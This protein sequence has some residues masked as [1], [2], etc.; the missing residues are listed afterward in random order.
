MSTFAP[1]QLPLAQKHDLCLGLLEEFGI[2]VSH[3]NEDKHELLHACRLPWHNEKT[4]SASLN[5]DKLAFRCFGCDSKGGLLWFIATMRGNSSGREVT[6]WLATATG[7]GGHEVD[8]Q[9]LLDY[10]EA[11]YN[12]QART[13]QVIP[14]FSPRVLEPWALVHP[15][16]TEV[17][18]IPEANLDTLQI[19]YDPV[20]DK[21]IIPHFWRDNLV[22]WQARK[23]P[24]NSGPKYKNTVDFPRESTV[25]NHRPRHEGTVVLVESPMSVLRH[26]HH[27]HMVSTFGSVVTDTQIR[28]LADYTD[29]VIWPDPDEAGW[30][31]LMGRDEG[32]GRSKVHVPGTIE[33]LEPYSSVRVVN[34]PW[35]A[36]PAE[37]DDDTIEDLVSSAVPGSIYT[38]PSGTLQCWY[39]K[40]THVGSCEE[41]R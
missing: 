11:V 18:G 30:T 28:I 2:T 12:P 33:R 21:I 25:Y 16:L 8:L 14:Q 20:Q 24:G 5:Y 17:R 22:G 32:K 23:L 34:S 7:L 6:D 31:S 36:D 19:G 9:A 41:R 10:I 38:P 37:L 1:A 4:P 29:I 40:Q 15:Y 39:C 3:H 26:V 35:F 27:T 13:R